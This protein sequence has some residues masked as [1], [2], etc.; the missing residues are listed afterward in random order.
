MKIPVIAG[1]ILASLS[2]LFSTSSQAGIN[3]ENTR[4]VLAAPSKEASLVIKNS[5]A[6]DLMFQ[7][8]IEG[9]D[10]S[11][12]VPFALTPVLKRLSGEQQQVLRILYSGKGLPTD[13]ESVFWLNV[14]E[15]PQKSREDN[16]LQIAV[17]QRLKLFYRPAG[18]PGKVVQAPQQLK[19]R[20]L[21][22]DGK[23]YLEVTNPSAFHQSFAAITLRM[24]SKSFT[25][26]IDM[27]A[28]T[29]TAQVEIPELP[30]GVQANDLKVEFEVIG[31]YGGIL[32]YDSTISG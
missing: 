6:E 3:L 18:L 11:E 4:V 9:A 30:N 19:W 31:D 27:V 10:K 29:T 13:K 28:P 16:T 26:P 20:L 24:G 17:Q 14:R 12:D 5:A 21:A 1:V 25:A 2:L 23:P 32:K 7:A 8:W 15:V 22:K